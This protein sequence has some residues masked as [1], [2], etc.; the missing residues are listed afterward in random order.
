MRKRLG[1]KLGE[2]LNFD[3]VAMAA[4]DIY[5]LG[6]VVAAGHPSKHTYMAFPQTLTASQEV[7]ILLNGGCHVDLFE[8]MVSTPSLQMAVEWL[9]LHG[10]TDS[11]V[12]LYTIP[13]G[14]Y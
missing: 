2:P 10:Y 12:R 9:E 8:A 13:L 3:Q 7:V 14:L 6:G 5:G 11:E 1:F 4:R